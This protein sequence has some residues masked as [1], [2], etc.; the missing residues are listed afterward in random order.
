ME[1][2]MEANNDYERYKRA[3]KQVEE[4]K[5]FYVHL[6]VYILV[7]AGLIYINLRYSPQYLWFFWTLVSWGIGLLFHAMKVF[8]WFPFLNKDWE[9]RKIKQYMEEEHKRNKIE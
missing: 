3:R 4:I 8:S 5:G 9:E 7:M 2:I 6:T 1:V